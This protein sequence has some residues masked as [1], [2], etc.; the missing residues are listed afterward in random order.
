MPDHWHLL[1]HTEQGKDISSVMKALDHWI[2][3]QSKTELA[4]RGCGCSDWRVRSLRQYQFV[5]HYIEGNAVRR[6]LVKSP[7]EWVWSNG[8]RPV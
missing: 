4:R 7:D 3:R 5:R 8:L 6:K 1:L 2:S